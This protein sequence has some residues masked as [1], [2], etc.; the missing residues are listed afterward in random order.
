MSAP[1]EIEMP[2][3]IRTENANGTETANENENENANMFETASGI[4]TGTEITGPN[5]GMS[6]TTSVITITTVDRRTE[7]L[8]S[9][10]LATEISA[11][12][13]R[14][15]SPVTI[16]KG[17]TETHAIDTTHETETCAITGMA[18]TQGNRAIGM[19]ATYETDVTHETQG[20]AAVIENVRSS[21]QI[22]IFPAV[23]T[24]ARIAG[25]SADP[26]AVSNSE[27]NLFLRG[28]GSLRDRR[29][30]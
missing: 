4:A 12:C 24:S 11:I 16:V 13:E 29:Q 30:G 15:E 6:R 27:E 26:T 3:G 10:T 7:T 22:Q 19:S 1:I 25:Q 8:V 21:L 23:Q 17:N 9:G 20:I 14:C 5:V 18:V 2:V 28:P